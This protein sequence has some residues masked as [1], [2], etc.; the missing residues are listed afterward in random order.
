M[1]IQEIIGLM[2]RCELGTK[3]IGEEHREKLRGYATA[4][5]I[6]MSVENW[7]NNLPVDERKAFAQWMLQRWRQ[8]ARRLQDAGLPLERPEGHGSDAIEWEIE[9]EKI[10]GRLEYVGASLGGDA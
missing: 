8:I 5:H 7:L 6:G 10:Q 4:G 1:K 2:A 3:T 9:W